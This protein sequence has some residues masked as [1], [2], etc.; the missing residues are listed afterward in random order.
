MVGNPG[1]DCKAIFSGAA[2][3]ARGM[4]LSHQKSPQNPHLLS[5][6]KYKLVCHDQDVGFGIRP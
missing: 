4:G 2:A 5:T 1:I 3:S 6:L